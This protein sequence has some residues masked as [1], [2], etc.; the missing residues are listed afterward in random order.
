[1][2]EMV[3]E[4]VEALT[5]GRKGREFQW[6][7]LQLVRQFLENGWEA[8]QLLPEDFGIKE[9]RSSQP[10]YLVGVLNKQIKA[11]GV[12]NLCTSKRHKNLVMLVRTDI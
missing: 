5:N 8:A 9:Y 4:E 11:L 1:M 7:A 10:S 6:K 3:I 12:E 2:K